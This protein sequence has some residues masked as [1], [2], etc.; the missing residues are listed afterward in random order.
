[1]CVTKC[2]VYAHPACD[3]I[4]LAAGVSGV[5]AILQFTRATTAP[6]NRSGGSEWGSYH[7]MSNARSSSLAPTMRHCKCSACVCCWWGISDDKL[8]ARCRIN[9]RQSLERDLEFRAASHLHWF[10]QQNFRTSPER[11]LFAWKMHREVAVGTWKHFYQWNAKTQT[12]LWYFTL[13][14]QFKCAL[15]IQVQDSFYIIKLRND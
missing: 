1:M 6:P 3:L 8:P 14:I 13:K 4:D 10:W 9:P 15:K 7:S 2:D 11:S 5:K 12:L